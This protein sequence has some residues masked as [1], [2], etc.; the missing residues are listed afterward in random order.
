M[1][2]QIRRVAAAC[3]VSLV[4]LIVNVSYYQVVAAERLANDPRNR[5]MLV[6]EYSI[7]RGQVIAGDRKTVLAESVPTK[8]RLKFL[9]RYPQG[10]LYGA[11]TGY[12]SFIYGS[13]GIEAA[14]NSFLTGK[15]PEQFT[16][17]LADLLTGREQTGD[18][19][20][21][22]IDPKLQQ[23]AASALGTQKGAIVALDPKT[24]AVLA[25]VS[26]PRY[27]PNSLAA[28][29]QTAQHEAWNKLN[30]DPDKPML[31]RA[32]RETYPPGS[33]FKLVTA[34]AA[35]RDG[36][37]PE[38]QR[39]NERTYT[40]PQT[41]KA[42]HNFGN[43]ACMGGR[44]TLNMAQA[45]QVS[46]N[47]WFAHLGVDLGAEKLI[48]Q[49]ER[50]GLNSSLGLEIPTATSR[51]P[52]FLDPAHTAQS[53][54]GQ[55]NDQV[56]PLQMAVI[57]ASIANGGVRMR[58]Y[59]VGEVQ[60]YTGKPIKTFRPS[61]AGTAL[62]PDQAQALRDMMTKVVS[63][64]TGSAARI[65]GFNVAGKTGTAQRAEGQAPHA[66]FVAFAPAEDPAIALA[67]LVEG[68]GDAGDEATGG[69]VAA[70]LARQVLE[71]FRAKV[72]P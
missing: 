65:E 13:G 1:N 53:A 51:I 44:A 17:S 16:R 61:I 20:I 4:V 62:E 6:K 45:L 23:A 34:A 22:T 69:R 50:F 70:P 72:K 42:I 38:I 55:Y 31:D 49:S 52:S 10:E 68:G 3:I 57:A 11:I 56:T 28:H 19:L 26:Y 21:L 30:A 63:Q 35:L 32:T 39:P 64:G 25:L 48:S 27:D 36:I 29:D 14:S 40:P 47:T 8:D 5:R 67:V 7:Q 12:Y 15:A 46:C 71:A 54:I 2:R 24:G 59:L 66:W 41:D 43:T 33:T 18:T 60:D 9:R 58:P 37:G